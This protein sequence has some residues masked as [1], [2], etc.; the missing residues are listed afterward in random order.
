MERT[1]LSIYRGVVVVRASGG[2]I[3]VQGLGP[4]IYKAS[5]FRSSM[6][7]TLLGVS[8]SGERACG[9]P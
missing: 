9:D 4:R 6:A 5:D 8:T 7:G 2:N 1:L 3:F